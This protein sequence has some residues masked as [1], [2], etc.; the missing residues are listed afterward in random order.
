MTKIFICNESRI[1]CH[2]ACIA[3]NDFGDCYDWTA[4]PIAAISIQSFGVF[5]PAI[6]ILLETIETMRFFLPTCFDKSKT[7]YG[8][9]HEEQLAGYG[10]GNVAAGPGFTAMSLLIV[11]AYLRDG[12]GAQI[13]SSY[14]K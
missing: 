10:Q 13:Y 2:D 5:Q 9:T 14:Y 6:N 8:G 3:G 11:N 4:H 7:S 1:N 12:F